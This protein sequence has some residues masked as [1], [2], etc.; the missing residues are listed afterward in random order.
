MALE[1]ELQRELQRGQTGDT[2]AV[3]P[4][5]QKLLKEHGG[6]HPETFA[7][8]TIAGRLRRTQPGTETFIA[9]NETEKLRPAAESLLPAEPGFLSPSTENTYLWPTNTARSPEFGPRV[10]LAIDPRDLYWRLHYGNRQ[11]LI[12]DLSQACGLPVPERKK[13]GRQI[14]WPWLKPAV[15]QWIKVAPGELLKSLGYLRLLS[16]GMDQGESWSLAFN[17]VFNRDSVNSDADSFSRN[18]N[19]QCDRIRAHLEG[20]QV[21][22]QTPRTWI[23]L[24]LADKQV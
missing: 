19:R 5:F 2:T 7:P 22:L 18:L 1:Y 15:A 9:V 11:E 6:I 17:A 4:P 24:K 14:D 10:I 16:S 21:Y 8:V 3:A 23:A 12:C 13:L 20:M